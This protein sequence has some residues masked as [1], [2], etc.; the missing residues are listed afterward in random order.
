MS[1]FDRLVQLHSDYYAVKNA[2]D[3]RRKCGE[4]LLQS[5]LERI[6]IEEGQRSARVEM[7]RAQMSDG[8]RTETVRLVAEREM[9]KLQECMYTATEE[10]CNAFLAEMEAAEIADS[11]LKVIRDEFKAMC[12]VASQEIE[13]MRAE[14]AGDK[15]QDLRKRWIEGYKKSFVA[16]C[17][18]GEEKYV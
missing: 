7:L 3:E 10:E 13:R 8:A 5:V 6:E 1:A 18:K 17:M 14:I 11:D 9:S 15:D 12:K 4:E 16:K 2:Y